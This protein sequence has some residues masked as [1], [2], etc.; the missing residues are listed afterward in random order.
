MTIALPPGINAL[1]ELVAQLLPDLANG[2]RPLVVVGAPLPALWAPDPPD[3]NADPDDDSDPPPPFS[4][5]TPF[6]EI[7][8]YIP[9][10]DYVYRPTAN[11]LTQAYELILSC[12]SLGTSPSG[13]ISPDVIARQLALGTQITDL[14]DKLYDRYTSSAAYPRVPFQ[15]YLN[16]CPENVVLSEYQGELN[17]ITARVV[18]A[19]GA[20]G[21]IVE[22]YQ[23]FHNLID[24]QQAP[25]PI[26]PWRPAFAIDKK[27]LAWRQGNELVHTTVKSSSEQTTLARSETIDSSD[28]GGGASWDLIYSRDDS[29]SSD[30]KSINTTDEA[31]ELELTVQAWAEVPVD[32]NTLRAG[33]AL[34]FNN[35]LLKAYQTFGGPI[36]G[37]TTGTDPAYGAN[38]LMPWR[39]ASVIVAFRPVVTITMGA[40]SYAEWDR[41]T[42]SSYGWGAGPWGFFGRHHT[43]SST[44][45]QTVTT[46]AQA[47]TVTVA[48]TGAFPVVLA[49]VM[50]YL[51]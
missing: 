3:P 24:P 48:D 13:A 43:S 41:A 28:R 44:N 31:I 35:S 12:L 40:K 9:E 6:N 20:S 36:T 17:G 50:E 7:V 38:G 11:T 18:N 42:Q 34:W 30:T 32:I 10:V 25:T 23:A 14:R 33:G 4:L 37:A 15:E 39:I 46:D 49:M 29:S 8:N 19:A 26:Q 51:P 16:S 5:S 2:N 27:I 47:L 22:A 1:R 45:Q 21:P